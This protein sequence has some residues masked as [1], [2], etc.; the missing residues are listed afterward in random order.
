MIATVVSVPKMDCTSEEQLVHRALDDIPVMRGVTCDL[1]RRTVRLFHEGAS[2]EIE[3]RLGALVGLGGRMVETLDS[4][5]SAVS[6]ALEPVRER[7]TLKILLA[8]DATMRTTRQLFWHKGRL[9]A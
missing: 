9:H 4:G 3:A 6:D 5:D 2:S 7:R 8:A 1:A